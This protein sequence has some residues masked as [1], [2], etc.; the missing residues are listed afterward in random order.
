MSWFKKEPHPSSQAYYEA[1]LARTPPFPTPEQFTDEF[2]RE[3][4]ELCVKEN[5]LPPTQRSSL[6]R[7]FVRE[8]YVQ[9]I[10]SPIDSYYL[11]RKAER[12]EDIPRLLTE[13]KRPLFA[14]LLQF[15]RVMRSNSSN[16]QV[17]AYDFVDITVVDKVL[18]A[19]S[20]RDIFSK[21]FVHIGLFEQLTKNCHDLSQKQISARDVE[22]GKR[23]YPLDFKGAVRDAVH[24]YFKGT[25]L[26]KLFEA[27]VSL[28]ISEDIRFQHQ[29]VIAPT[30]SG[31]TQLLQSQIADDLSGKCTTIVMDSQGL[32]EGRLLS[33]IERLK[34]FAPGG[35][36]D[37]KLVVLQPNP[38]SPLSLNLF[39]MGQNDPSLSARERQMMYASALK[40]ISFCLG[41][42]TE[43]QQDM[44]EYLV[45]LGL[46]IEGATIDT[47]R[48]MLQL[49]KADFQKEYGPALERADEVVRDY[50]L[51]SF[52]AQSMSVTRE[53]VMRRIMGMLKNPTFRKMYQ[54]KTNSFDMKKEI[55]AGKV[56]LINTDVALL[57]EAACEL[58]G[59]YF[60]SLLLLA[61]QQRRSDMPV[62]VYIDECQDY[63]ANDENVA[64]LLD[65]ARKQRVAFSF[66][67]QRLANIKSPNVLDA[68]SNCAIKFAGGNVTDAPVLAKYMRTT[69]EFIADQKPLSFAAF[70]RGQTQTAVSLQVQYGVME[71]MERTTSAEHRAIW[72]D[73]DAR[74]YSRPTERLAEASVE[75][76]QSPPAK[77]GEW[78][79]VV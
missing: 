30:G 11:G 18:G 42:T 44:I 56:I 20:W 71:G 5:V 48:R 54:A 29:W 51:H 25:P 50:F 78:D 19:F 6:Y 74:Y 62:H 21:S 58:F 7:D 65:K 64:T 4:D 69:P 61:T 47:V 31:K 53:A 43:Q 39:D 52:H 49:P 73:M 23:V 77:T 22:K 1:V 72:D 36:L 16:F 75:E 12:L 37:G 55:D 76:E 63:I 68:L 70:I 66:A 26:L 34:H 38:D 59:R 40:M 45:Q 67:H 3:F 15:R 79:D 41:G 32:E 33:N 17:P 14:V 57:G 2:L 24:A 46:E 13:F 27:T 10:Y 28:G 8:L 35:A 60:I 9:D